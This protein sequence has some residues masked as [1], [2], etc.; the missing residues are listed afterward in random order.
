MRQTRTQGRVADRTAPTLAS[1]NRFP[2][3]VDERRNLQW[4]FPTQNLAKPWTFGR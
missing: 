2:S 3:M 1:G 4:L